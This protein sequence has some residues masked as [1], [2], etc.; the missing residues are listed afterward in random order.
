[1][2]GSKNSKVSVNSNNESRLVVDHR[3]KKS[4]KSK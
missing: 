2:T 1:M 3:K 4:I